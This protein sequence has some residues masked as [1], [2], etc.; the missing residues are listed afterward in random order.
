M[1]DRILQFACD[2]VSQLHETSR[3]P[4][5]HVSRAGLIS[6]SGAAW[7][8]LTGPCAILSGSCSTATRG[9]VER[10]RAAH[11]T[12]EVT[13]EAVMAGEVTAETLSDF[14]LGRSESLPLGAFGVALCSLLLFLVRG[15][16][17]DPT[18]PGAPTPILVWTC[19]LLFGLGVNAGLFSV[20]LD[21]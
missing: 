16:I 17:F 9:Q 14:L 1:S 4:W 8:G 15:E 13:A 7:Q 11:P 20:P 21:A 3:D 19:F 18:G 10:H 12:L 5:S 6:G 2:C